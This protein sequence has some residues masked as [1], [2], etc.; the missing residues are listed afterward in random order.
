MYDACR[1][2]AFT[3]VI[4]GFIIVEV[5]EILDRPYFAQKASVEG[6]AAAIADLEELAESVEVPLRRIP[7]EAPHWQDGIVLL[8]A[9]QG[10]TDYL[11]TQDEGL[12]R[13]GSYKDTR[14]VT[15]HDLWS[16]IK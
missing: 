6:R 7:K 11:A 8:T 5:A 1:Q 10:K 12:L 15:L 3:L 16:L 4:S 13:L 2:G 14:I 9:E